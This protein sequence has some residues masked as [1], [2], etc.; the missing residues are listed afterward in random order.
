MTI[1][2]ILL[3]LTHSIFTITR[4]VGSVFIAIL[5]TKELKQRLRDLPET[6]K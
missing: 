2:N 3:M 4:K 6:L 5:H 1:I